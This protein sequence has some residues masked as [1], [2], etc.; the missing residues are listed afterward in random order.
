MFA[1]NDTKKKVKSAVRRTRRAID[2]AID[3]VE[4]RLTEAAVTLEGL[5]KDA[6]GAYQTVRKQSQD[7][8]RGVVSGYEKIGSQVRDLRGRKQRRQRRTASKAALLTVG[9]VALVL[10]V[11]R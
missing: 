6:R 8:L 4:P 11:F 10:G 5:G 7:G 3:S 2:R 9:A 1:Q